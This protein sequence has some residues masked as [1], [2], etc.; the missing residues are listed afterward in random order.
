MLPKIH[1]RRWPDAPP[2]KAVRRLWRLN[3][4]KAGSIALYEGILGVFFAYCTEQGLPPFSQ[5]TMA[6]RDRFWRWYLRRSLRCRN[7]KTFRRTLGNP[8]RAYSWAVTATG[9]TAPAWRPDPD[10]PAR[11]PI[12]AAYLEH[13]REQ[14]GLSEGGLTRDAVI[15]DQLLTHLKRRHRDWREVRLLDIDDFLLGLTQRFAP[16]TVGRVACALRSWLRFLYATGTTA[17]RYCSCHRCAG[18]HPP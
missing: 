15:I 5:L 8:L 3:G 17:T 7:A 6:G 12:I 10:V 2:K 9:H 1:D 11:P 16:A 13:A 14:R 18:T 4:L